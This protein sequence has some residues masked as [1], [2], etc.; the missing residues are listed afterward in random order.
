[1]EL[2]AAKTRQVYDLNLVRLE[3]LMMFDWTEWSDLDF[4]TQLHMAAAVFGLLVGTFVMIARRGTVLHRWMGRGFAGAAMVTAL[5]SFFIHEINQWG[6][7]SWI[8]GLSVYVVIATGISVSAIR[9]GNVTLHRQT[10]IPIY[11]GGFV[12]AGVFTL[13]PGRTTFEVFLEPTLVSV[14]AGDWGKIETIAWGF[15]IAGCGVAVWVWWRLLVLPARRQRRAV[16]SVSG[17]VEPTR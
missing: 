2:S 6:Q 12:V 10:M 4:V 14:F 16:Q 8:H 1:M 11:L 17:G 13:L 5:S 15:P 9:R 3:R 7:W